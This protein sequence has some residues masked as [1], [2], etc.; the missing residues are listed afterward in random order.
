MNILKICF[1]YEY[2]VNSGHVG[3]R[4]DAGYDDDGA[5]VHVGVGVGAFVGVGVNCQ[6]VRLGI[7]VS[8]NL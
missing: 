1:P 5:D 6:G 4:E 8:V 3:Q 2:S 7:N